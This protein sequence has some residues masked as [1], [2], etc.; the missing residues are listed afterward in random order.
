MFIKFIVYVH[1]VLVQCT[2]QFMYLFWNVHIHVHVT[3]L[4]LI[5]LHTCTCLICF[6]NVQT[7]G[8]L[9][10]YCMYMY[11]TCSFKEVWIET[12]RWLIYIFF[13]KLKFWNLRKT[14]NIQMEWI[15]ISELNV[16]VVFSSSYA[17]DL[18]WNFLSRTGTLNMVVSRVHI[19]HTLCIALYT[20]ACKIL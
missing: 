20:C 15:S 6:R 19:I 16:H 18:K 12:C 5:H 8:Q 17:V 11:V 9:I 1:A 7:Y 10:S 4:I 14:Y 13:C 2:I 3:G